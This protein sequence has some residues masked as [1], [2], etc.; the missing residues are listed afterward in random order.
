MFGCHKVRRYTTAL[1]VA[2]D[3]AL[4]DA[5]LVTS[6]AISKRHGEIP[7]LLNDRLRSC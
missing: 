2:D 1:A 4:S 3:E 7:Q 6:H 5:H